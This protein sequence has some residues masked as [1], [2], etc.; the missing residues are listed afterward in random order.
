MFNKIRV[1]LKKTIKTVK[2]SVTETT[3]SKQ[4]FEKLFWD[5]ELELIQCN[6]APSVIDLFKQ[7]LEIELVNKQVERVNV[8]KIIKNT[9]RKSLKK[10]IRVQDFLELI[11][12][13]DK[14]VKIMF[15]GFN[16]SGKTTTLA[17]I[18]NL[19]H[20][21]KLSCV[22]AACDTFRAASIE[23]L[24]VHAE[25]LGVK[26]IRHD[27]GSDSAAV[28]FDAVSHAKS[29]GL[30]CVLIDVAG[31]SYNNSNLMNELE[32][33]NRVVKPDVNVLIIDA[34][35]GSDSVNQ[36]RKFSEL[37]PVSGVIVTKTDSDTAGG[38]V[39]SVSYALDTPVF[40]LGTGQEY[41]DIEKPVVNDLVSKI[42]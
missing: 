38:T 42:V 25:N 32:K 13:F 12:G 14:P 20:D 24:G 5:L 37:I 23:Q 34:L 15:V 22:V 40:F 29:K 31:R 9:L 4:R 30:D 16:G 17:K 27:Y 41:L 28:A 2:E 18:I 8:D 35:T 36:A 1:A 6:V 26:M 21:N 3:L 7:E 10:T 39:I 33:I 19:L 11:K